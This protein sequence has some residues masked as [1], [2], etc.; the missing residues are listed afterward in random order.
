MY[1]LQV[2]SLQVL[3]SS[4]GVDNRVFTL[5]HDRGSPWHEAAVSANL[6]ENGKVDVVFEFLMV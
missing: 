1:G 2:G 5:S 3:T 6:S 4:R